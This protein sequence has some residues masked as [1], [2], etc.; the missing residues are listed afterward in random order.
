M[1]ALTVRGILKP[2]RWRRRIAAWPV[3]ARI[4][5]QPGRARRSTAR[6]LGALNHHSFAGVDLALAVNGQVVAELAHQHLRDETGA[7]QA[8]INGTA[9]RARLNDGVAAG[10]GESGAHVAHDPEA[11]GLVL[12]HFRGILAN[13][14]QFGAAP[15]AAAVA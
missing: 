13:L 7:G 15:L 8:A 9:R 5:P 1:L 10:A 6:Q 12:Q 4:H 2:H 11:A 14:A 3:I